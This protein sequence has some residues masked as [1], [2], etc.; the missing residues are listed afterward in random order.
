MLFAF[1]AGFVVATS[2]GVYLDLTPTG[3]AVAR[4][5]KVNIDV[6]SVHAKTSKAVMTQ[7]RLIQA[8]LAVL[9]DDAPIEPGMPER[10]PVF[11][12]EDAYLCIRN[13]ETD[14]CLKT[15]QWVFDP[16]L[17]GNEWEVCTTDAGVQV[18][19]GFERHPDFVSG[20][21]RDDQR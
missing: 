2:L 19:C 12:E 4:L 18:P 11:S 3:Q 21:G 9:I 20:S 15:D 16:P 13:G 5:S 17:R 1:V 6:T 7:L 14:V 10:V 8:Q